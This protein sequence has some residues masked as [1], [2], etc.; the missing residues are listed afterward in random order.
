MNNLVLLVLFAACAIIGCIIVIRATRSLRAPRNYRE[1]VVAWNESARSDF[2][3]DVSTW[4][5]INLHRVTAVGL[6]IAEVLLILSGS[7]AGLVP[8]A[9]S[10][11]TVLLAGLLVPGAVALMGILWGFVAGGPLAE[12]IG[13]DRHYAVAQQGVLAF[14][15]RYPWSTIREVSFDATSGRIYLWSAALPGAVAFVFSPPSPE[16]RQIL[17]GVLQEHLPTQMQHP[18]L[19]RRYSFPLLM[20]AFC[21]V[22]IAAAILLYN[23]P[24]VLTLLTFPLLLWLFL[25]AGSV[26]IMR[27]IY[28]GRGQPAAVA[29]A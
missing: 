25:A 7:A 13:G 22:F 16:Q 15:N 28:G 2:R 27:A 21:S 5:A 14:G 4:T 3:A 8:L 6:G 11:L 18:G 9:L 29:P 19:L 10:P 1:V 20:A 17:L 23:H 24:A 12:M 26:L